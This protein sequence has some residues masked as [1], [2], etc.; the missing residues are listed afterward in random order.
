MQTPRDVLRSTLHALA[1]SGEQVRI[2]TILDRVV[3]SEPEL[4]AA[5]A[6]LLIRQ[7][8]SNELRKLMRDVVGSDDLTEHG[9]QLRLS[10]IGDVPAYLTIVSPEDPK[11]RYIRRT[12]NCTGGELRLAVVTRDRN[13]ARAQEARDRLADLAEH[14]G[15]DQ[16]VEDFLREREVAA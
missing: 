3:Q 13:I 14:V 9:E 15:D 7:S 16:T 1:D 5:Y 2:E 6:D 8:L 11:D 4:M 12:L 10:G